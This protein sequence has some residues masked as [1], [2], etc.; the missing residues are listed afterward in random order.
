MFRLDKTKTI[1]RIIQ[2]IE[3]ITFLILILKQN[4]YEKEFFKSSNRRSVY[5]R[6][7]YDVCIVQNC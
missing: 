1:K 6:H 5:W 7:E 2:Q 4:R 3:Y